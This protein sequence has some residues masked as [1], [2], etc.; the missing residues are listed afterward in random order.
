MNK[1]PLHTREQIVK[2]LVEG[3]SLRSITRITGCS[4]NTVTKIL[5]DL[6]R[7]CSVFH[8]ETVKGLKTKKVQ[9]DEVWSFVGSKEKR[10]I[11]PKTGD[12]RGDIWTWVGIDA[13]S[14]LIVS[15]LAG[16]RDA[17][18]AYYF[19]N[20]LQQRLDNRIQLTT[21]GFKIYLEAIDSTFGSHVDYAMLVKIYGQGSKEDERKYSPAEFVEAKKTVISGNPDKD[22]I[23]T[24][25][26]ER[27]NLSLRMRNRRFTRLTNGFSKKVE[28]HCHS[29]ALYF[30]HY[31][32]CRV[33]SSLRVTPAMEAGL[34]KEIMSIKELLGLIEKY[35]C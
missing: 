26:V 34:T 1:L 35:K 6:G 21:D 3:S 22:S 4:I 19:M 25:F 11:D 15:W 28:N 16:E 30:V 5:V 23:S 33:H 24:S 27:Q 13:D 32:F 31:N 12:G 7:A 17:D 14:K 10:V 2:L 20:D 9:C 18:T 29:L 8:Y